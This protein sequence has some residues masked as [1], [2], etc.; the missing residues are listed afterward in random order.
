MISKPTATIL[1]RPGISQHV[2]A[3]ADASSTRE[4]IVTIVLAVLF[5][6]AIILGS[7]LDGGAVKGAP[8]IALVCSALL[9]LAGAFALLKVLWRILDAVQAR[10]ADG[11]STSEPPGFHFFFA[12]GIVIFAC[13]F[14]ILL[15]GF[16]GFSNYDGISQWNQF[17]SGEITDH[18]PVVHTIILS[19]IISVGRAIVGDFWG[20]VFLYSLLQ[21]AAIAVLLMWSLRR[22]SQMGM[23]RIGI[24]LS[25]AFYAL[26]PIVGM[27]ALS[28]TKD[29]LFSTFVVML[30]VLL[31]QW[32][33]SG[34]GCS[35]RRALIIMAAMTCVV[36][37]MRLNALPA[38]V[39]TAVFFVLLIRKN[40]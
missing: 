36:C 4:T 14:V 13:W 18:H 21:G 23:G 32:L 33:K 29:S 38:L 25:T 7:W 26:D 16:P 31:A 1:E 37:L 17:T 2:D 10:L 34:I 11:G 24:A 9:I 8:A 39:L 35:K 20:G 5:F 15:A 19:A 28:T 30:C 22:L 40:G 3:W 27:L 12:C 6:A